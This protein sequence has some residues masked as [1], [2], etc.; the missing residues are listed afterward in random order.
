[1]NETGGR[2][3]VQAEKALVFSKMYTCDGVQRGVSSRPTTECKRSVLDIRYARCLVKGRR[4]STIIIIVR[5]AKRHSF[6]FLM[7]G[8]GIPGPVHGPEGE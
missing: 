6:L 3:I 2:Y 7:Y 4:V 8:V 5:R 1:M